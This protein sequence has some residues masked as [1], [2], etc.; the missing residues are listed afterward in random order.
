MDRAL[1]LR[2]QKES[3]RTLLLH[4]GSIARARYRFTA[5]K[6]NGVLLK[7]KYGFNRKEMLATLIVPIENVLN[8]ALIFHGAL[9]QKG[10]RCHMIVAPSG[11]GKSTLTAYL[12]QNGWTPLTDDM[13]RL[14]IAGTKV[15]ARGVRQSIALNRKSKQ[16]LG[17]GAKT[18]KHMKTTFP[19]P[20]ARTKVV[21]LTSIF[22]LTTADKWKMSKFSAVESM[23]GLIHNTWRPTLAI[24]SNFPRFLSDIAKLVERVP[25][26]MI[27][28]P[29]KKSSLARMRKHLESWQPK[30][31]KHGTSSTRSRTRSR[32]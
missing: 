29:K 19:L 32:K 3:D 6:W 27:Q 21:P 8:G 14:K 25:C 1:K 18:S 7:S 26:E 16:L 2:W 9:L 30:G 31:A 12:M 13:S 23:N 5:N 10:K 28:Y 20:A 4:I 17:L 22:F 24:D 11:T 15:S